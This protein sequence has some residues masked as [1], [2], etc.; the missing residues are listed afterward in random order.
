MNATT[1]H[2]KY[3][4]THTQDFP[5]AFIL[6]QHYLAEHSPP[7]VRPAKVACDLCGKLVSDNYLPDHK[8]IVHAAELAALETAATNGDAKKAKPARNGKAVVHVKPEPPPPPEREPWDADQI[9]IPVITELT[10]GGSVP[11]ATL[12]A[13]DGLRA[14]FRW[15]EA[16]RAMLEELQ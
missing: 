7:Y 9:V 1:Y 3:D 16:T 11:V 12:V 2:C 4:P 8:R 13:P 14:L 5:N 6:G 10:A 15:H